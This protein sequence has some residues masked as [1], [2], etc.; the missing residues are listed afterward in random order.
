MVS[1]AMT[2]DQ[3]RARVA[4]IESVKRDGEAAHAMRDD[5]L[6]D[7]LRYIAAPPDEFGGSE[8]DCLSYVGE[9]ASEALKAMD[10]K[11][12]FEACA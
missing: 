7:V 9:L 1:L 4:Q 2:L 12:A 3:I 8:S 6:V 5:L 10:I 11:I